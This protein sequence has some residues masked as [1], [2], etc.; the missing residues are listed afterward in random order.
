MIQ[1]SHLTAWQAHAPWDKRSKIEQDLRLSRAV[2]AIFSDD[3]LA[4]HLALRGGTVLHKGHLAPAA[5]Y[6]EDLDLVLVK[7]IDK[8]HLDA[9]L[10]KTVAPV[11]GEPSDSVIADAWLAVRN[12]LKPSKILRTTYRYVPLGLRYPMTVKVEVNLDEQRSLYPFTE[13]QIALLDEDGELT[14][15]SARSYDIHE[16][17]GTKMRALMQRTQGRDLFDLYHAANFGPRATPACPIDGARVI[18]AFSWYLENE[19]TRMDRDE[20]E[21]RLA[22]Y[23]E[24]RSFRNDMRQLLRSDYGLTMSMRRLRLSAPNTLRSCS[25]YLARCL[26]LID[27]A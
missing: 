8:G 26:L 17:L 21:H 22:R 12:V 1:Q 13:V 27:P 7:A 9:R 6:S 19:G 16:M 24:D 23:L 10:R 2:A 20:A 18:E 11:L 3:T 4:E 25:N 15:C 14:N 5:R